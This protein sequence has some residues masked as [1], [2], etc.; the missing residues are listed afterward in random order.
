MPPELTSNDS[1][2]APIKIVRDEDFAY[3]YANHVLA[4]STAWDLRLVFG[5]FEEVD[6]KPAVR[7][8]VAVSLPFGLAKLAMYWM[9]T[10][11]LAHE[12]ETGQ[13]I[14]LRQNMHP[15]PPPEPSD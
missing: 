4:E 14:K 2:N 13:K 12:I 15:L 5:E 3:M 6:G 9:Q 7:Q 11:I 8:K 1:D 10:A